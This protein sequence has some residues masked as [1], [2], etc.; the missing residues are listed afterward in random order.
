MQ[1]GFRPKSSTADAL[2][3]ITIKL[4]EILKQKKAAIGV[5]FD[6][7]KAFDRVSHT[8]LLKKLHKAHVHGSVLEWFESYLTDREQIVIIHKTKSKAAKVTSGVPQGS[9]LGPL[10]FLIFINDLSQGF[11]VLSQGSFFSISW[12]KTDNKMTFNGQFIVTKLFT[13]LFCRHD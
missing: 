7:A 9:I 2:L 10:L 4:S 11:Q 6:F 5:A 1:F 3:H 13:V 12:H 8:V